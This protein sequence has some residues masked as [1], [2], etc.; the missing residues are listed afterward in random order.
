MRFLV[1]LFIFAA[2]GCKTSTT[3]ADTWHNRYVEGN[4]DRCAECCVSEK[5]D[6][7]ESAADAKDVE[8]SAAD[9]KDVKDTAKD[10]KPEVSQ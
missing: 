3:A 7:E 2:F 9:T 6:V 1:L 4:C 8:E 5:S 10:V